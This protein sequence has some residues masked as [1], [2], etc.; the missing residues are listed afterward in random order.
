M[1]VYARIGNAVKKTAIPAF[2]GAKELLK[3]YE[4]NPREIAE[5]EM[6]NEGMAGDE[7]M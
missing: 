1:P 7:S 2:A 5:D 3:E 6:G 4:L